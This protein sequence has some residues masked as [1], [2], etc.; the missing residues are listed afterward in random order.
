MPWRTLQLLAFISCVHVIVNIVKKKTIYCRLLT[1]EDN[2]FLSLLLHIIKLKR[3]PLGH[4]S[5]VF[6]EKTRFITFIYRTMRKDVYDVFALL[7]NS[8]VIKNGRRD[9]RYFRF[10]ENY[11]S[12]KKAVNVTHDDKSRNHC[13]RFLYRV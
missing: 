2:F 8:D 4:R 10:A 5:T 6:L 13:N 7:W 9:R 12:S 11:N 3:T 1:Q